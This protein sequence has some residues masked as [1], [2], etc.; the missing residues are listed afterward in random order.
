[1]KES[2]DH[3]PAVVQ[4][5]RRYT[6]DAPA[7]AIRLNINPER[8]ET[9]YGTPIAGEINIDPE[10]TDAPAIV[11]FDALT[12][13]AE[14]QLWETA[15]FHHSPDGDGTLVYRPTTPAEAADFLISHNAL[16]RAVFAPTPIN[17]PRSRETRSKR[18]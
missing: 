7:E 2:T 16:L 5:G 9:A 13:D 17:P 11:R 3:R 10:P 6:F 12:M 4:D 8:E 1:M 15:F 14:G 18:L